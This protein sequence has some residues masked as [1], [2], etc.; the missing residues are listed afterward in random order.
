MANCYLPFEN[1]C[2]DLANGVCHFSLNHQVL[3]TVLGLLPAEY[4][5]ITS[6]QGKLLTSH[7]NAKGFFMCVSAW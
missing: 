2:C 6:P 4:I 3:H 7:T 1:A 5:Q